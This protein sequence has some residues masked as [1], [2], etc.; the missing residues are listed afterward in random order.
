VGSAIP[1]LWFHS[2]S[3][4]TRQGLVIEV[5]IALIVAAIVL[6]GIAGRAKERDQGR[7]LNA[8][9]TLHSNSFAK[10]LALAIVAGAGS[11][12]QNLGLV[13]GIPLLHRAAELGAAQSYQ[14]NAIW[15]PLLTATFL[16]YIFFCAW[17]WRKNRSWPLFFRPK[18]ATHWLSGLHYGC[19]LV[20]EHR[21]LW[22]GGGA[23]G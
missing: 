7:Q 6:C 10:G 12:L 16:P 18:T 9:Q 17:L 20:F 4:L 5:G 13:F 21:H 1:L 15:A 11:A 22:G 2:A 3:V 23:N 8:T 14:A 19:S